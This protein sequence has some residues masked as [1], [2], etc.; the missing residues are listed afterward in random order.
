[1][2]KNKF[3][4][5]ITSALMGLAMT[6]AVGAMPLVYD[7]AVDGDIATV[8]GPSTLDPLDF[9]VNTVTG[10]VNGTLI[11]RGRDFDLFDVALPTSGIL[12]SIHL[13]LSI[14][15]DGNG[16]TP[17]DF[18][19]TLDSNLNV[20]SPLSFGSTLI[21]VGLSGNNLTRV[22]LNG[23]VPGM[24]TDY[25]I[26]FNVSVVPAVPVPAALPLFGTGLAVLGLIGWRRKRKTA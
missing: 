18:A 3:F 10:T 22:G 25:I 12:D 19:F 9:G 14:G 21:L 2:M 7:E 26:T 23:F 4:M 1:M 16:L 5:Y 13:F 8:T 24:V 6:T 17:I 11:G 20:E 15:E